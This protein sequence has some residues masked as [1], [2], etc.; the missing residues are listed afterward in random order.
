MR[1]KTL[2]AV[3][4][5]L[6]ALM[7]VA[8]LWLASDSPS[9]PVAPRLVE[10]FHVAPCRP[11][12]VGAEGCAERRVLRLDAT[13]NRLR[14][15]IVNAAP[16]AARDFITAER[17]WYDAR[18]RTCA[19][20]TRGVESLASSRCLINADLLHLSVLVERLDDAAG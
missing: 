8:A 5:G 9:A 14:A 12:L 10:T 7:I 20:R 2:V 6:A 18:E 17:S 4:V 16:Y 19:A 11:G 3:V 1:T 15:E 13:I